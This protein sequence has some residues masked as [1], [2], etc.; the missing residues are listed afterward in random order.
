MPRD[1]TDPGA[2]GKVFPQKE[3]RPASQPAALSNI[4]SRRLTV[5]MRSYPNNPDAVL[6]LMEQ[7]MERLNH[8]HIVAALKW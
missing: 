5:A 1:G 8:I 4:E 7:H 2:K 6:G 3:V